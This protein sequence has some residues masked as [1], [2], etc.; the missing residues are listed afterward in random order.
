MEGI[1]IN[2]KPVLKNPYLI[3]AWPGMGEVAFKAA[4]YL[5][6][7][8]KAE[9]FAQIDAQDF[10]YPTGSSVQQGILSLPELPYSKFY[11]WKN[12]VT[13]RGGKPKNFEGKFGG[14]DLIILLSN[15]QPDLARAEEYSERIIHIA[16]S[17]K[18]KTIVSFA[19]MPQPVDHTQQPNIW[20]SA[21]SA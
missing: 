4:Q 15:A 14:N 11:Y 21:T 7:K 2:K 12:P 13:K 8:L 10:F 18:V 1:I 6:D 17:F 9:E 3:C 5:V 16:R 20:F 19:S